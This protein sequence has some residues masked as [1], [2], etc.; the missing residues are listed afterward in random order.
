MKTL[1]VP[2]LIDKQCANSKS[3]VR[4]RFPIYSD[5]TT[6][7]SWPGNSQHISSNNRGLNLYMYPCGRT[8]RGKRV[9]F[10]MEMRLFFLGSPVCRVVSVCDF[11]CHYLVRLEAALISVCWS[12][13]FRQTSLWPLPLSTVLLDPT[14]S[15]PFHST[16]F[17]SPPPALVLWPLVCVH[18]SG[19]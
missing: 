5:D 19:S 16:Q 4:D 13:P 6:W 3:C 2:I 7:C 11:H 12:K 15:P 9:L 1:L 14:G 18:R 17:P 10:V 8:L